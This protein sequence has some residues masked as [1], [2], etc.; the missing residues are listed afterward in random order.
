MKTTIKKSI[1]GIITLTTIA[2]VSGNA[3][4]AQDTRPGNVITNADLA[5]IQAEPTGTTTSSEKSQPAG[6]AGLVTSTDHAFAAQPYTQTTGTHRVAAAPQP[7]GII[8]AAD[9]NFVTTGHT[10]GVFAA[11][12]DFADSMAGRLAK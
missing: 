8:T 3:A 1:A 12:S 9:Y 6:P 5:F 7:V 4:F 2:W 11:D 10:K